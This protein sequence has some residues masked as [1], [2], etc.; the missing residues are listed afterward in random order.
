MNFF[1][2]R[3]VAER[4]VIGRPDFHA[5]TIR[6]VREFLHI[7]GMLATALD[8]ACGTGLSTRA[9]LTIASDVYGTDSS[10]EMLKLAAEPSQIH[11]SVAPAE[12]QPFGDGEFDLITVC[13]A[14][15]WF[16]IDAF[17]NE[18]HRLL[19]QNG[20]LVIYENFFPGEMEGCP[21]F[22]GWVG[23]VYLS[24]FPSPP[25]NKYYDWSVQNLQSKNF[26]IQ[27]PDGFKNPI[28]FTKSQ[29]IAY[30]ITQSNVIAA[31]E[32]GSCAYE[33]I[34]LWLDG[35]LDSY[36]ENDLITRVLYY[37]NWI[38]YLRKT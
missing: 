36:F 32:R 29:L 22:T 31:V 6:R 23:N 18:A 37:G 2:S 1:S 19:K 7:D 16:D 10:E 27:T 30:F 14:I 35:Q 26:T 33:E 20:W 34:A 21:D 25:R 8:V 11:Y 4:Y 13:S 3:P 5:A 38:K 9:L 15:H 24:C 12:R 17:L 28:C